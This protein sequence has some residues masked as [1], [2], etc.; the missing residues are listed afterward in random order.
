[1]RIFVDA[2]ACPVKE[3][4]Y[5]VG[6]R[7][8]VPVIVVANTRL[9]VPEGVELVVVPDGLD[10]ADDWIVESAVPGDIVTTADIPLAHRV[11]TAG[12]LAIDFRGSEFTPDAIGAMMASREI[13]L[14]IRQ[15]GGFTGGPK[16]ISQRDRGLFAGK[17]DEAVV[18]LRKQQA[19]AAHDASSNG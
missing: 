8:N 17:L 12:V 3:Q 6:A 4:I 13:G 15:S 5:R 19:D 2:D 10:A 1:M 7:Y 18:R 14:L 11:V 9:R 16:P